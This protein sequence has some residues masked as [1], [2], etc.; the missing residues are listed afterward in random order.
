M[1]PHWAIDTFASL[2]DVMR[3]ADPW[4][5]R[6]WEEPTMRSH[7]FIESGLRLVESEALGNADLDVQI[8][9]VVQLPERE[10]K[11]PSTEGT[12]ARRL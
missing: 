9:L 3:W 6:I 5:E 1:R 8:A 2:E 4:R 11:S 12:I 10:V 7:D